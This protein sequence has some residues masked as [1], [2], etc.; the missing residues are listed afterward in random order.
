M[1]ATWRWCAAISAA[2]RSC[3]PRRRRRSRAG[4]MPSQGRY[5]TSR[6]A[7]P[8]RARRRCRDLQVD[9]HAARAA[10]ARRL[11]VAG[12]ARRRCGKTLEREGAV[13]AVPQPA[14]LCAAD[15]VPGLRPPLPV[16]ELLGLAG[17]ASLS[18]PA[19]SAIIAAT[20]SAAPK[21]ARNAARSTIWSPAGRASSASPRRSSTHFPDARTIVL[22]TDLLGGV[23]AAAA[24][25]GG[26]RRGRGRHRHRHAARR[27]GPQFPAT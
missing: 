13:A 11:P 23:R 10:G 4:S 3:W 22:S 8:L 9:R 14:R 25:T 20:T 26:D 12:A 17:R 7:G 21:P 27:Q 19:A 5:D 6:A 2:S 16:P 15:A 18:R 1:P 24:G